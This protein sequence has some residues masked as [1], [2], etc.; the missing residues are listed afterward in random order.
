MKLILSL[1]GSPFSAWVRAQV[2]P[3]RAFA[4]LLAVCMTQAALAHNPFNQT[5]TVTFEYLPNGVL[6]A[7]VVEPGDAQLCVRTTHSYDAFGNKAGVQVSNCAGAVGL[8]RVLSRT[9]SSTYGAQGAYT[10]LPAA[11]AGTFATNSSVQLAPGNQHNEERVHDVRFGGV[12]RLIGPNGPALATHW[13]HDEFGRKTRET[14]ADGTYTVMRHCIL[15]SSGLNTSSNSSG[16]SDAGPV[17]V[18]TGAVRFES[19]QSFQAGGGPISA[20]ARVYY[21]RAGQVLRS[22]TEGF[23]G[24]LVAQDTHYT[25]HGAVR[26]KTQ[27]YFL[28]GPAAGRSTVA[29]GGNIHGVSLTEYDALGRAVAVFTSEPA[30]TGSAGGSTAGGASG[31]QKDFGG[32]YGTRQTSKMS[33]VHDGMVTTTIDDDGR[34]RVEERNPEGKVVRTTDTLGAQVSHLYDALGQLVQTLDALGNR[35][36]ITYDQRGRK[37]RLQDP[38]AGN[39]DYCYDALGQLKAQQTSNQR[40][41]HG[42]SACPGF[43]GSSLVAPPTPGWTTLAYDALGRMVSRTSHGEYTTTWVYDRTAGGSTCGASIG[44]PCRVET[45]HGVTR[46]F[47]YDHLGR[48]V[49]NRLDVQGGP[50][51]A[52]SLGYDTAGRVATQTYPTGVAVKYEYHGTRGH[53]ERV[54]TATAFTGLAGGNLGNVNATLWRPLSANAWGK[55][56]QAEYGNDVVSRAEYEAQSGRTLRLSAG[57]GTASNVLNQRLSWDNVGQLVERVD[58]TGPV[59]I[60]DTYQ[61]DQIG[62]L[63]HY[64]VAGSGSPSTR[65]VQLQYNAAGML[66]FKSDVGVYTYGAQGTPNGRPHALQ[67]VAGAHNATYQYDLNGNVVSSTGGKYRSV[68][69]TSFN[70]PDHSG[71]IQGPGGSPKFTWKYDDAQARIRETRESAQGTRTTWYWHPD[72]QGGLGFE[73]EL[74]PNGAAQN[75]HFISAGGMVIGVVVTTGALP[76]L[77]GG[78]MVPTHET[79]IAVARVEFWH[80]D[81]LG[82]LMAS[83]N[84]VG[85]VVARY[86][87]D[88]F[89]KRRNVTGTYDAFGT[90]VID[91]SADPAVA[92]SDRGYTGH[93]HLDDVGLIHMNGRVFDPLIGRFMQADPFVQEPGNLQNYDR[94]AY[95]FNSPADCTDPSG[96]IFKKIAKVWREEIW[97]SEIGRAVIGVVVA[98]YTAGWGQAL[99]GTTGAAATAMANGAVSGFAASMAVTGGDFSA[100]VR[101]GITG[102]I[103]A[104]LFNAV[105]THFNGGALEGSLG[106]YA[107]HAGVGCA[108]ALM[109][110]G[111]C[112]QGAVSQLVSKYATLEW[113]A[114][115]FQS[116]IVGGTVSV[117]GGGKFA[118]GAI[119]GAF[120][121]LFNYLGQCRSTE[122]CMK[123]EGY[124]PT[125][126]PNGT[127]CN[128]QSAACT[129]G[130]G[131]D[132][133]VGEAS[134]ALFTFVAGGPVAGAGLK[135]AFSGG[136]RSVFWSGYSSGALDAASGLGRTLESTV[137]GRFLSWLNHSVG[138]KV[139]DS[140]W[141]W[142]SSTFANQ[143][144]GTAQAVIRTEGRVWT[145]IEKPI[146]QQR[147]IPIEYRP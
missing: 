31:G 144:S 50:S 135:L 142:A 89:G 115:V 29:G 25:A 49:G 113:K 14:R 62:R 57:L 13:E 66:L 37:I 140:V 126:Y 70:L 104:G 118:N 138:I 41:N 145:T 94:Y 20:Q 42:S 71:G 76:A 72:N 47:S 17:E 60:S 114:G 27:P 132:Q 15:A 99:F 100:A 38:D 111:K 52:Q 24:H 106:H 59:H 112:G 46:Q 110:G 146:L 68:A 98:Y 101:D 97:R 88:P 125:Q 55:A 10:G 109:S 2:R 39:T 133:E 33:T 87:Y 28:N 131:T 103:T 48:P 6:N 51:M 93:E 1:I 40:G 30:A 86:S 44:K 58:A 120:G 54:A 23:D 85:A 90:L 43:D 36:S 92:G 130:M 7:E 123:R 116:A 65:T 82:S 102:A 22:V 45:D 122:E 67:Q 137:G 96:L 21:D 32:P 147:G 63:T 5:R 34:S 3:A 69:Y 105:G 83:T 79:T 119:T 134:V 127:V 108:S 18:P 16:C 80:K 77:A 64:T 26:T 8:A 56:E 141:N 75:R 95:C 124:A 139:P 61:Y 9:S 84:H 78:Q 107:A 35:I 121:Y 129:A 91:F 81:H 136:S 143:A 117:I 128:A 74:S 11:P 73:R 19:S 4:G 12:L 53:L